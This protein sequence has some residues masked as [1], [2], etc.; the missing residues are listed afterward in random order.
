MSF[1]DVREPWHWSCVIEYNLPHNGQQGGRDMKSFSS[2]ICYVFN[3]IWLVLMGVLKVALLWDI[4]IFYIIFYVH[5]LRHNI[6]YIC[7]WKLM[8]AIGFFLG[9]Y[10]WRTLQLLERVK[11]KF[12]NENNR[13]KRRSLSM[14]SSLQHFKGKKCMLKFRDGD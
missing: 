13:R 4:C 1:N 8:M 12:K 6:S 2:V 3:S 14:L 7:E 11:C 10:V 9:N 5:I